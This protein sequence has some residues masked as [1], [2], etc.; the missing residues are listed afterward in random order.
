[1]LPYSNDMPPGLRE[2]LVY[3]AIAR[4]IPVELWAPVVF[5]GPRR[6]SMLRTAVPVAT[7]DEYGYVPAE[8]DDIRSD[9]HAIDFQ[10]EILAKA[11]S[12]SVQ[13]RSHLHLRLRV[14]FAIS[15]HH[16]R[17]GDAGWVG[18]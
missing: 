3:E 4:D 2:E 17:C 18:I 13:E 6:N 5:V 15:T 14:D 7:V 10:Q 1:M 8:E 16:I 9:A 12:N 11:Q